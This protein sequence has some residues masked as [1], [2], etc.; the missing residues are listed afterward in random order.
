MRFVKCPRC[1]LNYMP[2][3]E[4]YCSVCK[5]EILGERSEEPVELCSICNENP[6]MPGKDIC[7]ECYKEM[8][9]K[10]PMDEEGSEETVEGGDA[11]EEE[12]M[13]EIDDVA[14]IE[15][16]SDMEEIQMEEDDEI[17]PEIGD[18]VSLEEERLRE[19]NEDEDTEP[20][21]E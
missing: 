17:P 12:G 1:E 20:E 8:N 3:N 7:L 2:E 11:T 9:Q 10:A 4:E 16:V 21:D 6:V 15:D 19:S 14:S 18:Q 5:R 13:E